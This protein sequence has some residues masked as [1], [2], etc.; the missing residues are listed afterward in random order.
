MAFD[1]QFD[2]VVVGSGAGAL[3]GAYLAARAGLR[4]AVVEGAGRLGGTS[5]YS[6]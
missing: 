4:T 6:G 3:T 1:D 2:V 5:A